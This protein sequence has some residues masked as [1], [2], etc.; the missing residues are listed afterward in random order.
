MAT[1]ETR[2]IDLEVV[3]VLVDDREVFVTDQGCDAAILAAEAVARALDAR[4]I[5]TAR[6]K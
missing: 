4:V 1:V 3:A 2:W 5:P 6:R